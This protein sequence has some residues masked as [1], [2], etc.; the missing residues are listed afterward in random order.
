[1]AT[2][3]V[4]QAIAKTEYLSPFVNSGD[5]EPSWDGNIYAYSDSSKKKQY[6][7]GKAPIQIKG[8]KCKELSGETIKYPVS[9]VD[10]RNYRIEGGTIYFVVHLSESY[11]TKIY[12]NALLPFEINKLLK[13]NEKKN[14]LSL[15][16][17]EFPSDSK[18]I[19]NIILNFVRD[20]DKQTLLRDGKNISLEELLKE[21][22]G[23]RVSYSFSYTGIGYDR[24][25]PFEYLFSH[26]VY[27]YAEIKELNLSI[28]I[29]HM[30]RAEIARSHLSGNVCINGK[31]YYE[32]Y[33]VIHTSACDELHLGKSIIFK[34]F[35]TGKSIVNY[36]LAGNL[37]ERIVAEEFI[38]ELL[39]HKIV[40]VNGTKF[41]INPTK[42]EIQNFHLDKVKE[43]LDYLRRVQLALT[44]AGVKM[45]LECEGLSDK[46]DEY[47]KI[48]ILA[49]IQKR[50]IGFNEN[51]V[52][53]AAFIT[54]NNL[55]IMLYFKEQDDGKYE[56]RNFTE[57]MGE[58]SA[59]YTNGTMFPTSKYTIFQK[60]DYLNMSNIDYEDLINDMMKYEN[61]GNYSRCNLN[62][63]EMLKAYDENKNDKLLEVAIQIA[64]WLSKKESFNDFSKINLYQCYRR[65]RSLEQSEED[66]LLDLIEKSSN[67]YSNIVGAYILLDNVKLVNRYLKRLPVDEQT[68]FKEYPIWN[69]IKEK[70]DKLLLPTEI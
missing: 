21:N 24:D 43:H 59:E 46:D 62:M 13:D 32:R 2:S 63:L 67:N 3:A 11:E 69:L 57:P 53:P 42:E 37:P 48:L 45:P 19:S 25:K 54:I 1:M 15:T 16:F 23:K 26:D 61:E 36:K 9:V 58:W 50:H 52:P 17:H 39:E 49:F 70:M 68:L 64:H 8:K 40:I 66:E 28:P 34:L 60:D 12:H 22:G 4:T 65:K 27:M 20:R 29:D 10:L 7:R 56:L 5:K 51:E 31:L 6:F 33:D 14:K 38:V 55:R 44:M 41:E 30:W 35:Q 47:I 18:E